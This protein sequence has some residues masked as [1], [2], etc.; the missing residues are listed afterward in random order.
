VTVEEE[1]TLEVQV[2]T[3]AATVTEKKHHHQSRAVV[4]KE[5]AVAVSHL[6]SQEHLIIKKQRHGR[7]NRSCFFLW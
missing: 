5:L 3:A 1:M 6:Q 2:H 4:K 7:R